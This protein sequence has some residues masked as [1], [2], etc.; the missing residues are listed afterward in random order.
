MSDRVV[1]RDELLDNYAEVDIGNHLLTIDSLHNR[2]HSGAFF[3][4]GA[5]NA[6]LGNNADLDVL[7]QTPATGTIHLRGLGEIGG[8]GQFYLFEDTT[9]SAAGTA[10]GASNHN[11]LSSNVTTVTLTHTPTITGDGTQLASGVILGGTGGMASGGSVTPQEWLLAQ[12]TNYLVRL[13]NVS[14]QAQVAQL[15]IDFYDTNF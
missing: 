9:F 12:S 10:L 5:S 8:D 11:R 4:S 3:S 14:G 15:T 13:T 2:I 6:A 1:I 7:I